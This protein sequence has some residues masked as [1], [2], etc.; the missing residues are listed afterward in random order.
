MHPFCA[1]PF[2]LFDAISST[3]AIQR[4]IGETMRLYSSLFATTSLVLATPAL[5]GEE[6][7]Y[8]GTPDW[9]SVSEIDPAKIKDGPP[10][11]VS[12]YQHRIQDGV[13]YSYT[14]SAVRIDNPQEL[15]SRGTL[16]L[17]WLPDKGD[18]TIHKLHI[19][20]GDE[21]IDLVADGHEFEVIRRERGLERRLLDGVLTATM[22]VPGLQVG[23]ILRVSH[24]V[25]VDDQA[26]GDEVQVTQF[27]PSEPWQVAQGKTIVSWPKDEPMLWE[28][29]P[30]IELAAPEERDGYKYLAIEFPVEKAEDM[31]RDAPSRFR[32]T[33]F[34]RVGSFET[35]QDLSRV[36]A[37]HFEGAAQIE[38][39]SA[40]AIEAARIKAATSDPFAQMVAATRLAQDDVSYLLNGLDGGNYL[41]QNAEETWEKR[42]GDC[43]AKSVLLLALLRELGIESET[44]LVAS[45]GG[46]AVAE[47][48]P[49]PASFDHMIVRAELD[50]K[51]YWIDGTTTGARATNIADVPPFFYALP[52]RDAGADL[53]PMTQ[54]D[55]QHPNVT[56]DINGDFSA[57][58]DLPGLIS[59]RD[60]RYQR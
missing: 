45:R 21:T 7:L 33:R 56:F 12:D 59:Q 20:R 2:T 34:L 25:G 53:M 26:L 37:P 55:K 60:F 41:P 44:V 18:L 35:W 40:L 8:Q 22:A 39:E 14:D 1:L 46:D 28:A 47:M 50:G 15:M 57:G 52:L 16:Q 5:A 31:P 42:Y 9:V 36:M 54:R 27:I 32:R 4:I 6:V 17:E 51:T 19:I 43:K 49:L 24:S 29:G 23:D 10:E 58:A 38:S 13:V 48:I 11:I 30:E 3:T